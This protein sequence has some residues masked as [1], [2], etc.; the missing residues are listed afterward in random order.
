MAHF[1]QTGW[2]AGYNP[3][4]G[5]DCA[6]Y[7]ASHPDIAQAGINPALHYI[8]SGRAEGRLPLPPEAHAFSEQRLRPIFARFHLDPQAAMSAIETNL[9]SH[10]W[11][12]LFPGTPVAVFIH[13]AGNIFMREI[14]EL[15]AAGFAA[16]GFDAHLQD[17]S[18]V[19][20]R[21]GEAG[22]LQPDTTRVI[23]APHEFF[24]LASDN[25]VVP[26][27]WGAGAIMLNVEQLHTSWFREGL[28]SLESAAA[29]VDINLQSAAVLAHFGLPATYLPLGHV[30][31]FSRFELQGKLPDLQSLQTLERII[32]DVCPLPFAP[33]SERPIDIFFIGYLSHR[34]SGIFERLAQRLSRWRCHFVFTDGDGPQI[35]GQN[36]VLE[37]E[38][39]LGLAQ[40]SKII[41]NLHQSDEPFFE[42]HRIVF[43]GIWQR[44][45]VVS[46]PVTTQTEFSAGD[47]FLEAPVD[48]LADVIDWVLETE[49]GAKAAER[50]R[51]HAYERLTAHVRLEEELLTL[52]GAKNATRAEVAKQ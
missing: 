23:V 39:T 16:A 14:A 31:N 29:I 10:R 13:S 48:E 24:L 52:F 38:A 51:T 6:F 15:L 8:Q 20:L 30:A 19:F 21:E 7:L 34:R 43:Q 40:R 41:L 22:A 5:F 18:A 12:R 47:H 26:P 42:W 33:L 46:E 4:P 25:R 11:P 27:T 9:R 37:S 44:T 3:G 32:K 45:L 49:A 50:I 1:V 36:A 17:E 28:A 2:R 35:S